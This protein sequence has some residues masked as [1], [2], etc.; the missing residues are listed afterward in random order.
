[1]IVSGNRLRNG[2]EQITLRTLDMIEQRL[3]N[4]GNLKWFQADAC[5]S[6]LEIASKCSL[7]RGVEYR[8][9]TYFGYQ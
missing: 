5:I 2:A 1:M 3:K 6:K 9:P 8:F 7:R 4:E